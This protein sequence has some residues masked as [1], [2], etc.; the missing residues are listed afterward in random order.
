MA[1]LGGPDAR[2]GA[3]G[4]AWVLTKARGDARGERV[5]HLAVGGQARFARALRQRRIIDR[6]VLDLRGPPPGHLDRPVLSLRGEGDDEVEGGV[7]KLVERLRL[8]TR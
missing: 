7:V 5:A 6:P 4:P 8:M 2:V 3:E 1:G